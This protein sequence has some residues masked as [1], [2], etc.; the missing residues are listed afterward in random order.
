MIDLR[1]TKKAE[2]VVYTNSARGVEP[3]AHITH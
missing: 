1:A 2:K 3:V